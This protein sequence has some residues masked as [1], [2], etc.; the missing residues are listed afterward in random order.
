MWS[1]SRAFRAYTVPFFVFMA[2]L[3]LG[4][5]IH[6]GF[7]HSAPKYWI[8]P[9]QT[10][11]CGALLL[12]FRREYPL[13]K[14]RAA[15]F[16]ALVGIVVLAVWISPQE[17][18]GAQRRYEGFDPAMVRGIWYLPSLFL[19]FVRLV[20]VV[21]LLE[22][23]FWR[24]FLLRYLIDADF[25]RVPFGALRP[26]PFALVTLFFALAHLGP[27]FAPALVTGALYN[28]VACRTRSLGACVFAH[29]LT[30]LLLGFYIMTTGQWGFW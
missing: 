13:A 4:D 8:F 26:I 16:A 25:E 18:F 9:L 2:L 28:V 20:A 17:L 7:R 23:I 12:R 19:R 29:A 27:D 24:G 6:S 22:E 15:G 3:A 30:N 1:T 5:A 11:V 14:P 10:F 21:P